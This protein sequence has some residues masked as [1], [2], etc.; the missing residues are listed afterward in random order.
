MAVPP[1]PWNAR[2]PTRALAKGPKSCKFMSAETAQRSAPVKELKGFA[3]INLKPGETTK[4]R[5]AERP[6]FRLLRPEKKGWVAE[7]GEFGILVGASSRD[8]RLSG[9]YTL[10]GTTLVQ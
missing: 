2:S 4:I 3:K 10:V 6:F 5:F 9:S 7:A 8:I 1:L